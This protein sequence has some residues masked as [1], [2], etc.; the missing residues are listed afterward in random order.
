MEERERNEW[1]TK[2]GSG[3]RN[4]GRKGGRERRREEEGGWEE[5]REERE[6]N[7]DREMTQDCVHNRTGW[8][9]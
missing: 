8:R 2:R 1:E 5:M 4:K 3:K 9:E 7:R 6:G